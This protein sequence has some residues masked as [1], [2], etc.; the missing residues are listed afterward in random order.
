MKIKIK[1]GKF[2]V[3]ERHYEEAY[4]EFQQDEGGMTY[5][6]C[7][8]EHIGFEVDHEYVSQDSYEQ[9]RIIHAIFKV[10]GRYHD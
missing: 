9:H 1:V 3:A 7:R 5:T 8:V 10:K 2:E 4:N 6:D